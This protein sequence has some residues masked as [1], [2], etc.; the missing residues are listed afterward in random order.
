MPANDKIININITF[1]N[2]EPTEALT[3]YANDKISR[4]LGKFAHSDTEAHVVLRVEKNRQIAEISFRADGADFSASEESADL[5]S[6]IDLLVDSL[7]QQL[8]KHKERMTEKH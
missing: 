1:R 4:C 3:K 7:A 6:A 5:Y 8:R 2:T